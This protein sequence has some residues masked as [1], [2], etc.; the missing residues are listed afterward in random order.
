MN[1]DNEPV[2]GKRPDFNLSLLNKTNGRR[3]HRAGA[4]WINGDGSISIRLDLCVCITDDPNLLITLFP[5][6][7]KGE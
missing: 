7:R 6:D 2:K 4:G 1:Q 5:N 3:N